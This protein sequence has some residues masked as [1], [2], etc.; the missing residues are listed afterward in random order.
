MA[1][2]E[3][4]P[5]DK[6]TWHGKKEQDKF[7]RP[8][9]IEALVDPQTGKYATGLSEADKERLEKLLNYDLS[10]N[11]NPDKPHPFWSSTTA[12]VKLEAGSNIFNT[13]IPLEEIKVKMMKASNLVANSLKEY[14]DGLFPTAEFVI[15]DES[16]QTEIKVQKAALKR[17]VILK[18]NKLS[19]SKKIEIL[20]IL[21]NNNVKGKSTDY[22]NYKF[23]EAIELHGPDKVLTL[24]ERDAKR[25]SVHAIIVEA[26]QKSVL[27]KKNGTYF[28]MG[29]M[30][31]ADTEGAIDF[32]LNDKNQPLKLQIVE[33]INN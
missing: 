8:K 4:R 15:F 33:K 6:E 18:A 3:V 5:V 1:L 27:T 32:F 28:Y 26:V 13:D 7:S 21:D 12:Q 22:I 30:I 14:E 17:N 24:M 19:E 29:D 23:D 11:Y 2:V 10:D 9:V 20:Q 25:N 16:E 31:A